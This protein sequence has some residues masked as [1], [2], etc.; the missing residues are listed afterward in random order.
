MKPVKK[1]YHYWNVA[2]KITFIDL[3]SKEQSSMEYNLVHKT[4]QNMFTMPDYLVTQR[5]FQVKLHEDLTRQE[6]K[7]YQ[8]LD[9]FV[10]A[11]SHM[12]YMLP[13]EMAP[14]TEPVE[15]EQ[16]PAANE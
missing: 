14:P 15:A 6:I 10:I 7:D 5:A 13:S 3:V 8:S 16:E 11:I 12:G 4:E 1:R 9:I 2:A